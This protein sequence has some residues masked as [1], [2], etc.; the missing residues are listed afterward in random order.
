[1]LASME[2]PDPPLVHPH[3]LL[4][5][6]GEIA[7]V[8]DACTACEVACYFWAEEC[9]DSKAPKSL[10]T[11][12]RRDLACAN[13]CA[14]TARLVTHLL[15]MDLQ[16]SLDV[17]IARMQLVE[18]ARVCASCERECLQHPETRRSMECAAACRRCEDACLIAVK[19][20]PRSI[21]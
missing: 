1:M 17:E 9:L 7:A 8:V 21:H 5:D 12:L 6:T 4:I 19:L 10:A 20:L 14:M 18:C 13:N 3:T 15:K 16:I 2:F 11:S